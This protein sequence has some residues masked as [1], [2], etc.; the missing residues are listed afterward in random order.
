M[1]SNSEVL[2]TV[3]ASLSDLKR[4]RRELEMLEEFLHQSSLRQAGKPVAK[5]PNISRQLEEVANDNE[6]NLLK[7]TDRERLAKF[8]TLL[9][10]KAPVLHFTF[11]SEPSSSSLKKLLVWLRGNIHPQVIIAISIQPAIAVG[12]V[13]RTSNRQFDFSLRQS[14]DSQTDLLI[15]TIRAT[16]PRPEVSAGPT[17]LKIE[18]VDNSKPTEAATG[19]LQA[20]EALSPATAVTTTTSVVTEVKA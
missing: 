10:Q 7:K 17:P 19:T 2:S 11:A 3:I 5:L 16:E 14:L 9:V 18:V 20:A 8:L 1:A 6:L 12:C 4:T 15:K 13:L